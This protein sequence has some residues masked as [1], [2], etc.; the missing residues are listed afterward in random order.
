V[1]DI[2]KIDEF[3][4]S[5]GRSFGYHAAKL[6]LGL[7]DLVIPGFGY[8]LQLGAGKLA[9]DPLQE[10]RVKWL[11]SVGQGLKELQERFD[12]FDP[13]ALGDN[14]DFLSAVYEATEAS[15]KTHKAFKR[16]A[17]K[18][19][20]LNAAVNFTVD[21]ALRGRFMSCIDYFTE[22]HVRVL[23]VLS[24][25]GGYDS[26]V[27][28]AKHMMGAQMH[29]IRAEIPE[30]EIDNNVFNII[31]SDLSREGMFE[32]SLNMMVSSSALLAKRSTA[33]GDAFLRFIQAP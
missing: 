6:G 19:T 11:I 28:K 8:L 32:G 7:G 5:D 16:E 10:R 21:D 9:G 26:C 18:N 23:E 12:G 22:K 25:P 33:V 31:I 4:L 17:L 1:T 29:V 2:S 3:P 13:S 20:V 15:M 14:E 30:A 27:S 24:N